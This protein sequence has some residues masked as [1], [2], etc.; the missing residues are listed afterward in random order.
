[1]LVR[2]AAGGRNCEGNRVATAQFL[3]PSPARHEGTNNTKNT[4]IVRSKGLPSS[5]PSRLGDERCVPKFAASAGVH[6]VAALPALGLLAGAAAGF[7]LP[8]TGLPFAYALL[9][10][11]VS[12]CAWAC[13]GVRPR[14]VAAAVALAFAAGGALLAADAWQK[15]WRPTLRIA[16]EDLARTERARAAA[17]RRVLPEDDEAFAI[18]EGV[19]RSDASPASVRRFVERGRR[20]H[21]QAG[22]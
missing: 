16:F 14:V 10:V 17:E 11:G 5:C 18:V 4:K 22:S 19:L 1:M 20:P 8:E 21:K 3:L 13:W 7:L 9:V 6:E 12:V 2:G 15:A